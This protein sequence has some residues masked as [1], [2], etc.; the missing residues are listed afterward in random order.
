MNPITPIALSLALL[1]QDPLTSV[2]ESRIH[3]VQTEQHELGEH[4][5]SLMLKINDLLMSR[6]SEYSQRHS[7]LKTVFTSNGWVSTECF[8]KAWA[9]LR[10]AH[11]VTNGAPKHVHLSLL[12]PDYGSGNRNSNCIKALELLE[13][14]GLVTVYRDNRGVLYEDGPVVYVPDTV[15]LTDKGKTYVAS[16]KKK[17]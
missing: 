1:Q 15:N 10:L 7:Q 6:S 9:G 2:V 8:T 4:G 3:S 5:K 16:I 17:D 14:A 13:E 11:L 12:D